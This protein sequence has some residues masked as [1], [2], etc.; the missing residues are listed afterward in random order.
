MIPARR[1][2]DCPPHP[3]WVIPYIAQKVSVDNRGDGNQSGVVSTDGT[4]SRPATLN[5]LVMSASRV[6][7]KHLWAWPLLGALV[8]L[9]VGLWVRARVEE[10]TRA[11]IVAHLETVLHANINA[12]RLWFTE[13]EYDAKSFASDLRIQAAIAELAE[14]ARDSKTPA[15]VLTNSA[16]SHTLYSHLQ[17]LVKAQ[18]YLS[19]VVVSPDKRILA[20]P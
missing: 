8:F 17:P 7:S 3:L 12:L 11:E 20:S 13:R 16:A 15:P 14:L 10:T 19:Y 1:A 9:L 5:R 6:L 18:D 2:E 4:G